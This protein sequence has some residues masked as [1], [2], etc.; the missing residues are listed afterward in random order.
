MSQQGSTTPRPDET[1]SRASSGQR[2]GG[3]GGRGGRGRGW[4]SSQQSN[5]SRFQGQEPSLKECIFDYTE[6]PQSKRYL[7]NVEWLVGYVGT[8]FDRHNME[9]QQAIETLELKDPEEATRPKD[10]SDP[11]EVEEWKMRYKA[12]QDQVRD[13]KNFRAALFSLILGQ[14]TPL[15]KDKLQAKPEFLKLKEKRDGVELLKLIKQVTFTFD[16][17]E[18]TTWS[19]VTS[20]RRNFTRSS[21]RTIRVYTV[22]M[23]FFGRKRRCLKKRGLSYMT[24]TFCIK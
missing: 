5:S 18:S 23:R 1:G 24:K 6:D 3:R 9:F 19:G 14:C 8:N 17:A 22:T 20:S 7:R 13:Y 2:Q 11:I 16:S 10:D 21:V 15:M 12:R 4:Q